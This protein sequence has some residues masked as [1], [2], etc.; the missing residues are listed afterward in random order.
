MGNWKMNLTLKEGVEFAES[1]R[2]NLKN[3]YE[4]VCG[5]CPSFIFLKDICA[6]VKGSGIQV[7]AQN[8]HSSENGPYTGEV[9]VLMVKEVGCSHVLI[10]HSER[11][12]L[13][14]ETDAFINAKIKIALSHNVKPILCVGEKLQER[15]DGRTKYVV[16]NQI[17]D[18]LHGIRADQLKDVTIAYEP[19]WA[20]GTGKT[21]LPEQANEVHTF[22]RTLLTDEY[23]KYVAD[24]LPILYGGSVKHENTQEL[25][26]KPDIDG[27]LVGGASIKLES[28]LKIIEAVASLDKT[29][30]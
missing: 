10:G 8:I 7:A 27:L 4:M 16:K 26:A 21:A 11:R 28:F 1:L 18:G 23:G 19:V 6:A 22:I 15:E 12:H 17:K 14:G 9:S 5:I 29:F 3:K 2:N 25:L 30:V 24:D 20:I 13:F